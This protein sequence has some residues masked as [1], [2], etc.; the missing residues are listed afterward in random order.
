[1][2]AGTALAAAAA[3]RGVSVRA[4]MFVRVP[5]QGRCTATK[6]DLLLTTNAFFFCPHFLQTHFPHPQARFSR[7]QTRLQPPR[8][9]VH[10]TGRHA[11]KMYYGMCFCCRSLTQTVTVGRVSTPCAALHFFFCPPVPPRPPFTHYPQLSPVKSV[12]MQP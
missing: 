7:G 10:A 8:L 5:A 9:L 11:C 2:C 1:M 6:S 4:C 3:T 12:H